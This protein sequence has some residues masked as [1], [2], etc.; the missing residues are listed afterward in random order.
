MFL[1]K[2]VFS[3]SGVVGD[4]LVWH[5]GL[6]ARKE[7]LIGYVTRHESGGFCRGEPACHGEHWRCA[8]DLGQNMHLINGLY[9]CQLSR[10]S[11]CYCAFQPGDWRILSELTRNISSRNAAITASSSPIPTRCLGLETAIQTAISS[12]ESFPGVL[13]RGRSSEDAVHGPRVRFHEPKISVC[14]SDEELNTPAELLNRSEK[15]HHPRRRR[16][17]RAY[18][19]DEIYGKTDFELPLCMPCAAKIYCVSLRFDVGLTGLL[20][21]SSG[22]HAMITAKS[23]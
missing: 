22:Y 15:D 10:S 20:R 16:L 4:S 2:R 12:V 19:A 23:C 21:F 1:L 11:T 7:E 5:H 9:D 8:G 6:N 3:E 14:P 18:R 13:P 17:R